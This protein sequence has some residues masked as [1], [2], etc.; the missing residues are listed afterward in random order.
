MVGLA[1]RPPRLMFFESIVE[2]TPSK[3]SQPAARTAPRRSS[4]S[5]RTPRGH[6][7]TERTHNGRAVG[8]IREPSGA[9]AS[10]HCPPGP[11]HFSCIARRTS[12]PDR[13]LSRA[14]GPDGSVPRGLGNPWK[15]GKTRV[16]RAQHGRVIVEFPRSND[17]HRPWAVLGSGYQRR[18][19]KFRFTCVSVLPECTLPTTAR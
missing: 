7:R 1:E 12:C 3:R 19:R 18:H 17:Y 15:R 11:T 8:V 6:F 10:T 5:R 9:G 13:R 16:G 14:A 4:P 2:H